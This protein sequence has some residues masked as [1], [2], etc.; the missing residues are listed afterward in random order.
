MSIGIGDNERCRPSRCVSLAERSTVVGLTFTNHMLH[1]EHRTH[2][3]PATQKK[4]LPQ[5]PHTAVAVNKGMDELEFVVQYATPHQSVNVGIFQPIQQRA[6]QKR[7]PISR[8]SHMN[9]GISTN[10]TGDA[11]S[12]RARVI[13]E[14]GHQHPVALAKVVSA[15]W[16]PGVQTFV[17]VELSKL[18]RALP[19]F[20]HPC[21]SLLASTD[22][23]SYSRMNG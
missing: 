8:R 2:G 23:P 14:P 19:L 4:R 13:H 3:F 12:K 7:Y 16:A 5:T 9:N 15:I 6:D 11:F 20:A 18:M 1:R 22:Q 21:P 10:D 17:G